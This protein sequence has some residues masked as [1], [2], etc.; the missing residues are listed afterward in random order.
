MATKIKWKAVSFL[1]P[2]DMTR[3]LEAESKRQLTSISDIV[4][5]LVKEAM[6][7]AAKTE[8]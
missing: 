4:R 8:A 3:W 1:S 2:P 7:H 5:R 6:N